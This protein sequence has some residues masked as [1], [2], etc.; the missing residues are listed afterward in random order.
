MDPD[1]TALSL[2]RQG[3]G[4]L[5]DP[6]AVVGRF[7][8]IVGLKGE[9]L[10]IVQRGLGYLDFTGEDRE[11]FE[12]RREVFH[13]VVQIADER[14]HVE[15]DLKAVDLR[16]GEVTA[17]LQSIRVE[18]DA[19]REQREAAEAAFAARQREM[20]EQLRGL[21]DSIRE[22]ST[23]GLLSFS[24]PL[25]TDWGCRTASWGRHALTFA[26]PLVAW[27]NLEMLQANCSGVTSAPVLGGARCASSFGQ[28]SVYMPLV[29]A[30]ACSI[31]SVLA[32]KVASRA[33]EQRRAA[34]RASLALSGLQDDREAQVMAFADHEY[35]LS[36][37]SRVV[38]EQQERDLAERS[39][40]EGQRAQVEGQMAA[41]RC[42]VAREIARDQLT[43]VE[44]ALG[45]ADQANAF[46]RQAGGTAMRTIFNAVVLAASDMRA[47]GARAIEGADGAPA[48]EE[49]GKV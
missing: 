1:V 27:G 11:W 23:I 13:G 44:G 17:A 30:G 6:A 8:A 37:R 5:M 9:D 22:G 24:N 12:E 35:Y 25:Y 18:Q 4:E 14:E 32:S 21:E 46:V 26:T 34:A 36:D 33:M 20:Q 15:S 42:R 3:A 41:I 43:L 40:L 47:G 28:Q 10:A 38:L 2:V 16:M 48:L 7:G 49:G 39:E 45:Q 31:L 19:F 29:I